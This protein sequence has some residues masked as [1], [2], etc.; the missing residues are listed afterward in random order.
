MSERSDIQVCI[1]RM[2]ERQEAQGQKLTAFDEKLDR[3]VYAMEGNGT[4]GLKTRIDRL[5]QNDARRKWILRLIATSVVGIVVT[6][7]AKALM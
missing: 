4:P 5:E 3:L 2:E 7:V 1:A 6:Q